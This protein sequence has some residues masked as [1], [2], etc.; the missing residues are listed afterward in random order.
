MRARARESCVCTVQRARCAQTAHI[1][2][3]IIKHIPFYHVRQTQLH[4]FLNCTQT[5]APAPAA[6]AIERSIAYF[7]Y[8]LIVFTAKYKHLVHNAA[9]V[10]V[11][12][13]AAA[14]SVAVMMMM[15]MTT[16]FFVWTL[17]LAS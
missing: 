17:R 3:L 2:S 15:M 14:A 9:A 5:T 6:N 16:Q 4:G 11:A 13:A 1:V 7:V 8:C 10:I 12:A